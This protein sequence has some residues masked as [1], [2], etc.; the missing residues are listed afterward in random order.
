MGKANIPVLL[1]KGKRKKLLA[2]VLA[3]TLLTVY[4]ALTFAFRNLGT[5]VKEAV[6]WGVH[7]GPGKTGLGIPFTFPMPSMRL[8]FFFF[9]SIQIRGN[10]AISWA[11]F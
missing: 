3:F 11:S 2:S 4:P 7:A 5:P 9:L 6:C 8:P 1:L 10:E